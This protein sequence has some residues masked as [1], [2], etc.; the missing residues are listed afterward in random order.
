MPDSVVTGSHSS[1][2]GGDRPLLQAKSLGCLISEKYCGTCPH[3]YSSLKFFVHIQNIVERK[4]EKGEEKA[5]GQGKQKL[6]KS[7]RL[8]IA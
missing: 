1:Y 6:L 5:R 4:S 7:A 8:E 2:P 3:L